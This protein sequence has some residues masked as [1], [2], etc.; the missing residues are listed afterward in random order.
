MEIAGMAH[1]QLTV[2]DLERAVEFYEKVLGVPWP[3]SSNAISGRAVHGWRQD[4]GHDHPVI[5]G[6]S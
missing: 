3:A 2:N 5:Q 4:R 6:K 1:V